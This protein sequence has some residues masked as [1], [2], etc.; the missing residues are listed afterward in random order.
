M[1]SAHTCPLAALGGWETGGMN[2]YVRELSRAL[3]RQG[4]AVDVFTRRQDPAVP[5]VVEFGPGARVIHLDAGPPRHLDKYEALEYLPELACNLQRF[6]A[7]E[8]LSYDVI[9][10]HYWLSG[11]LAAI[12]KERWGVPVVAMF[13]TLARAKTRAPLAEAER[14]D[15]IRE[16]IE[17]RLMLIASRIIAATPADRDHMIQDYG[18][19]RGAITVIPCGVD[20]TL[21]RPRPRPAA[22]RQLGLGEE[23]VLLFVGRIQQ[24]KGIDLLLQSAA[25]LARDSHPLT[26]LVVGGI[27]RFPDG[28]VSPEQAEMARLLA[29]RD[30][31]GL[32]DRVRFVGAVDQRLLPTYYSAADVTVVPSWYES[33]GLVALESMA[34]GTP[35]V[36]ARVGGLASLV[37]DGE[38]GR[39]VPWR[40][41]RL[42][43]ERIRELCVP[44]TRKR[45]GRAARALAEQYSW[46]SVAEQVLEVY[47]DVL[48]A[49]A[50][51][52][53]RG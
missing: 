43:A 14:E 30:A 48:G 24:L 7:L 11:R 33:F 34:C 52:T 42:Y 40:D 8:G 37:R 53:A 6:R 44:E 19:P 39:L 38:T 2:V 20:T 35:V 18:A 29:I 13:H 25:E 26:V 22:R 12:F 9:H 36:A 28:R 21:F 16:E 50:P 32:D 49:A 1:L 23:R 31:L 45:L 51:A 4:I 47:Q 41:P 17:Q 3:G 15:A 5:R 27:P 10:S 46:T